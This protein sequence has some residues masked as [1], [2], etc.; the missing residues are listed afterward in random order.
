MA[1]KDHTGVFRSPAFNSG[2]SASGDA[3]K[4]SPGSMALSS[5]AVGNAG[6]V[7]SAGFVGPEKRR[8]PRYKCE[9]GAEMREESRGLQTWATFT[10][11]SLHGCY[12][13]AAATYPVGTVLHM[14][15]SANG[16]EVHSRGTVRVSYPALGMGIAF[17]EMSVE[18]RSRLRELLQT[19]SRPSVIMGPTIASPV[20]AAPGPASI[21]QIFNPA[22]AIQAV[23]QF[24]ESRQLLM[25]EEFLRILRNSQKP[26]D[27]PGT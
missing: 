11:I 6:P 5:S 14:K 1:F 4:S 10:D 27:L 19:V 3:A 20:T 17:T 26:K 7:P 13:E 8:S 23:V 9:G 2:A 16:F 25:R 22:A 18:D 12:V 24:F 21:P 15:L